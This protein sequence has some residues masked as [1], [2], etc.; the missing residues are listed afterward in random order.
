MDKDS[1][2]LDIFCKKINWRDEIPLMSLPLDSGGIK[3][4]SI[5]VIPPYTAYDVSG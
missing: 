2:I 1:A 3:I 5:E 4:M